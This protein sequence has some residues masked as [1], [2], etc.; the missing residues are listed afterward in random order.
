MMTSELKNRESLQHQGMVS[1]AAL[2]RKSSK[3]QFVEP[4]D[5]HCSDINKADDDPRNIY[6]V[7]V[8]DPKMGFETDYS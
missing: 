4:E 3:R 1:R 7:E 5:H 6:Y 8:D 2:S